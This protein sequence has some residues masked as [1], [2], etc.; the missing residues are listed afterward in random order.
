MATIAPWF[1]QANLTSSLAHANG[2]DLNLNPLDPGFGR[3]PEDLYLR[4]PGFPREPE[5]LYLRFPGFGSEPSGPEG[6]V[7]WTGA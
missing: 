1:L 2:S 6:P 3:E 4:F 5:D 7:C